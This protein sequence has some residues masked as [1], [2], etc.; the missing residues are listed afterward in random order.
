MALSSN[1]TLTIAPFM[2]TKSPDVLTRRLSKQFHGTVAGE[3]TADNRL[4]RFM[5][6]V[7]S[8]FHKPPPFQNSSAG[9]SRKTTNPT[10]AEVGRV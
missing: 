9:V 5:A 3:Y 4:I 1:A 10:R 8:I 7:V 2:V 6:V